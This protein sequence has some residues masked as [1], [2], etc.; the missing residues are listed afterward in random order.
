[1]PTLAFTWTS[2]RAA[3]QAWPNDAGAEYLAHLDTLIGLGELRLVRD[4]NLE[5][6]D[7][8]I[9]MVLDPGERIISKPQNCVVLRSLRLGPETF[10][11]LTEGEDTIAME[12]GSGVLLTEEAVAVADVGTSAIEQRSWDFCHEFAPDAM[13]QAR[14]R[15]YNELT[16]TQI[17]VV[18]TADARYGVVM[19]YVRRPT[20]A[21]SGNSPSATSWLSRNVPD[22]LF[23][24]CLMEAENF[25]KADDRYEDYKRKYQEEILPAARIELRNLIRM[26]DYA[27]MRP[28]AERV[29]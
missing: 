11:I 2:L 27:P 15:Y 19:R 9:T 17:E 13:Q 20:D 4:L 1:M 6:F 22:A 14:P 29:R 5:I 12:D 23:A 28:A 7:H 8:T 18:P 3:L 16:D 26:G 10:Y 24:A 21:L 25:L